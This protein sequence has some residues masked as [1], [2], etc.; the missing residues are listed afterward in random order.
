MKR[1][2]WSSVEEMFEVLNLN[3]NYL[4]LRNFEEIKENGF[5]TGAHPDIDL[6]CDDRHKMKR[7]LQ[8]VISPGH[9]RPHS[10]F[11][12]K[13][14]GK[15]VSIGIHCVGESYYDVKW[16]RDMFNTKVL[17]PAG[18][19]VMNEENYFYS[20]VYHAFIHQKKVADDYKIR[21]KKMADKLGIQA[22]TEEQLL[23][24][25]F[26]YMRGKGYFVTCPKDMVIP[27][28]LDRVPKEMICGWKR[29]KIKRIIYFPVKRVRNVYRRIFRK[30][31]G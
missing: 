26:H 15:I 17:H 19:Y 14:G 7:H 11:F 12:V 8:I 1:R 5:L 24:E 9:Y 2:S 21:L 20:L 10:H 22:E 4:V 3:C 30:I 13:I 6:L 25:L 23:T 29:W 27:M 16:E 28:K 31:N 18:F